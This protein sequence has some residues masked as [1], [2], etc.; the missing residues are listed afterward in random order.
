MTLSS[1]AACYAFAEA[2]RDVGE[3]RDDDVPNRVVA[4]IDATL[5]AVVEHLGQPPAAGQR[6][7]A[8]P[9]VARRRDPELLSEAPARSAVIRDRDDRHDAAADPVPQPPKEHR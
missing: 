7:Q 5:E 2:A 8:V 1:R 6:H 3:R 4:Q 9:Y